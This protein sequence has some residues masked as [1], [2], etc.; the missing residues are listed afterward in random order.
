LARRTNQR[1]EIDKRRIVNAGGIFWNERPGALPELFPASGSIDWAVK[2]KQAGQNASSV[3]FDNRNWLIKGERGNGIGRVTTDTGQFTGCRE[4]ARE[5][6]SMAMLD[7]FRNRMQIASSRVI[8]EA[9]PRVEY[10]TFRSPGQGGEIR[11]AAEPLIIIRDNG[12]NLS[13]LEH[14]LGDEDGVGIASLAPGEETTVCMIP[15]RQ[16]CAELI[17]L[18]SHR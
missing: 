18:E 12:G 11:E 10:V 6:A 13:L 15:T 4:I 17:F 3:G 2:I 16:G 14:E 8:A 5:S 1:A 7:G 9:L